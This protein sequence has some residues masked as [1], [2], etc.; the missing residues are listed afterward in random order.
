MTGMLIYLRHDEIDALN[1]LVMIFLESA[2]LRVRRQSDLTLRFWRQN[3]DGLLIFN[4][5]PVLA[6]K[7]KCTNEQMVLFAHQQYEQF[8]AMRRQEKR[9]LADMEDLKEIEDLKELERV[10]SHLEDRGGSEW[11]R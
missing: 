1:R 7:G 2:E 8:D 11:V 4:G 3:V 10:Q 9:K 6:H 5:F